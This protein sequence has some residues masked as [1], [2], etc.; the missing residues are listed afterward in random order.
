MPE[1]SASKVTFCIFRPL[2][3]RRLD[4]DEV[5]AKIN[6]GD[7]KFLET[8]YALN[9]PIFIGWFRK[10]GCPDDRI[11]E[12]YQEAFFLFFEQVREGKLTKLEASV[13]TYLV[14]IG[15][16]LDRQTRKNYW[17]KNV[18][19]QGA[20]I[21]LTAENAWAQEEEDTL[22]ET[23]EKVK[24]ALARL[25]ETCRQILIMFYYRRFSM[26]AI[27]ERVNLKNENTAKKT[28]YECLKKLRETY[29]TL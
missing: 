17:E 14:G 3:K 12:W 21:L 24:R 22:P 2:S 10:Q 9:R 15:K 19:K 20:D 25:G 13:S 18:D 8:V 23:T 29:K 26:E 5:I 11:S 27:A 16:N 6:S 28:K 4:A 7:D 1:K